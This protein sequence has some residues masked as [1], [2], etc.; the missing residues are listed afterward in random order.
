[1]FQDDAEIYAI[2]GSNLERGK[3]FAKDYN[4]P[5][6][7]VDYKELCNIDELDLVCITAPN[8]YHKEMLEYAISKN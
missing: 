1:M 3:E 5:I 8:K 6:A 7:C 2:A 4:I